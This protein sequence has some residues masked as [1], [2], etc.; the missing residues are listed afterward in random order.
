M[1]YLAP[2]I[3]QSVLMFIISIECYNNLQSISLENLS[4][5]K[6]LCVAHT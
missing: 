4:S 6:T 3:F 5:L 2:S 1:A